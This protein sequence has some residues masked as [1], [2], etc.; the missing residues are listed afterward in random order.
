MPL[1]TS[2]PFPP[3]TA[4]PDAAMQLA[5]TMLSSWGAP[6]R[7]P[8]SQ[9]LNP[10]PG[11]GFH[12]A[13]QYLA[14]PPLQPFHAV[15]IARLSASPITVPSSQGPRL[16]HGCIPR[17]QDGPSPARPEAPP[18]T[19][20]HWVK[21]F[22][23]RA[24]RRP[25]EAERACALA[26]GGAHAVPRPLHAAPGGGGPWPLARSFPTP[27]RLRAGD[28]RC[29]VSQGL[30][31]NGP[32]LTPSLSVLRFPAWWPQDVPVAWQSAADDAYEVFS[33]SS[34]AVAMVFVRAG[35]SE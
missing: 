27:L 1:S 4:L 31:Q 24:Q 29:V 9:A 11:V 32:P 2:P 12:C 19:Q 26:R 8:L 33:P 22:P 17:A 18:R 7:T 30:R 34:C 10:L 23:A 25:S 15:I 13:P 28:N 35:L 16:N 20:Q 21:A 3:T 14:L 6:G 5:G